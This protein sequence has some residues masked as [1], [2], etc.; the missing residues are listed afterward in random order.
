MLMTTVIIIIL[1]C[2]AGTVRAQYPGPFLTEETRPNGICFLPEPPEKAKD[3]IRGCFYNDWWYYQWGKD[4]RDD[5]AVRDEGLELLNDE[6]EGVFND[7][8]GLEMGE[9]APEILRLAQAATSD[10]H[11][12]TKTLKKHY[13]CMRPFAFFGEPSITPDQDEELAR[14]WAYPSGHAARGWMFAYVLSQVAPERANDLALRANAYAMNRVVFGHHWKS[15]V[16]AGQMLAAVIFSAVSAT[17]AYQKQL[18]KARKEY[19]RIKQ[20]KGVQNDSLRQ[21]NPGYYYDLLGHQ[22]GSL[23]GKLPY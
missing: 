15:D 16:D 9:K 2:C 13:R 19:K 7:I 11:A 4:V 12:A 10:V 14:E 5:Y 20:S 18:K 22:L 6:G 23:I 21:H 1:L 8:I 17:D 3:T